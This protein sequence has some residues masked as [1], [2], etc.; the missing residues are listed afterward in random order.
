[1]SL[2]YEVDPEKVQASFKDG[3]LTSA[4]P[5]PDAVQKKTKKI[6]IKGE[7]QTKKTKKSRVADRE[8][9][10]IFPT[11]RNCRSLF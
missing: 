6:A 2:P 7:K 10:V 4:L 3:V 1:M 9:T 11:V 8:R 5:K